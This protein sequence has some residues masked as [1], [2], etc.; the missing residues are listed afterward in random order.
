VTQVYGHS[1]V[2]LFHTVWNKRGY[3]EMVNAPFLLR[4]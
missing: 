2:E 4:I 1:I 3:I